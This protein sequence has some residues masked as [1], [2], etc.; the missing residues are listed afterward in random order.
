MFGQRL[1]VEAGKI[2]NMMLQSLCEKEFI[3]L[4]FFGD[5]LKHHLN[6]NHRLFMYM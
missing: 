4:I 6:H 3:I 1:T 5:A 2:F